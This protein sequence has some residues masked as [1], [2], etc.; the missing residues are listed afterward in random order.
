MKESERKQERTERKRKE[1]SERE[2]PHYI[3]LYKRACCVET[4]AGWPNKL[5]SLA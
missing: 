3:A 1:R 5:S 4:L 2:M